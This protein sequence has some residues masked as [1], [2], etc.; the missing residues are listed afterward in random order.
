VNDN[1]RAKVVGASGFYEKGR[2]VASQRFFA[3]FQASDLDVEGRSNVGV[4]DPFESFTKTNIVKDNP[5]EFGSINRAFRR[6]DITTKLL[7][8]RFYAW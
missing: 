4:N 2:F 5:R 6:Q 1:Q 8:D 7:R 3:K